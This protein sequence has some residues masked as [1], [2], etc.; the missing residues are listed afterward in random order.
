MPYIHD[1][2]NGASQIHK[3]SVLASVL[4]EAWSITFR[5]FEN[6]VALNHIVVL[7]NPNYM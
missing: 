2:H 6:T 5:Y 7:L 1:I 4:R 3:I